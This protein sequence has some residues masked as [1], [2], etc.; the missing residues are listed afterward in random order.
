MKFNNEIIIEDK[1]IGITHPTLFIA[2][3]GANHD[4]DIERAKDLIYLAAE[5]GADVAKFQHFTAK[6]I[7]SD[8]GFKSLGSQSSHQASW[9]KSVFDVYDEASLNN[10]WTPILK[11]VCDEAGI[12]FMTSPYSIELVES[13]DR[14]L[15]AYK[16]GSGDITWHEIIRHIAK[17]N[18][19][20]LLAS[21]ASSAD[22]VIQAM[23]TLSDLTQDIV[24]MQCNTNYTANRENFN[25]IHLNVLKSYAE[26][27]PGVV[28]GLSDHTVGHS[29]VLGAVS[30][31]ARVIEKHF[32]DSNERS[33][34]DHKFAMNP[35][36]WKEMVERTRELELS[37]GCGIKKIED[38]EKETVILQRRSYYFTEDLPQGS[39]ISLSQ[40]E[41]LRPSPLDALPLNNIEYALDKKTSR[42]IKKGECLKWEHLS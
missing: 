4:G 17:K 23:K 35:K 30:L 31:G 6:T 7:V 20:V 13:V 37:L 42:N 9:N 28:L 38:N 3:I 36:S 16:I 24:L 22:E 1:K 27:F 21:G 25:Y 40:L 19:P 41:A 2:D 39:K 29:T 12:T 32:T 10:D 8:A 11:K 18:K 14:F 15:S 34:P 26:M 33:G 5:N